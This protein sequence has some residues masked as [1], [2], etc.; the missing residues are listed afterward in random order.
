MAEKLNFDL[1]TGRN[2]LGKKL[3]ENASK[4]SNLRNILQTAAGVFAGAIAVKAFDAFTGAIGGAIGALNESIQLSAIQE[5]AVNDLNA[6]LARAGNLLPGVSEEL[7]EFASQL[8]ASSTFGDEVT[9][10]NI[11]LLQSLTNLD[12]DGLKVATQAAADLAAVQGIDLE[13]AIRLVGRAAN[14]QTDALRRY[15][16]TVEKGTSDSETF[17]NALEQ[18]NKQF[19][20]GAASQLNT[21]AGSLAQLQNTVGDLKETYGDLVTQNPLVVGSFRALGEILTEV[22]TELKAL[23]PEAQDFVTEGLIALADGAIIAA[24]ATDVLVR[25]IEL[26]GR[27][28][29]VPVQG[30]RGLVGAIT[31][32]VGITEGALDAATKG[33]NDNFQA[34]ND[35]IENTGTF[36]NLS[37]RIEDFK[38][39]ALAAAQEVE[40]ARAAGTQNRQR[41]S[42]VEDEVNGQILES[43]RKLQEELDKLVIEN[44]I[45]EQEGVIA[46]LG[47]EDE[48]RNAEIERLFEFEQAKTELLLAQE[49]ERASLL[50]DEEEKR[51]ANLVA[52]QKKELAD[53][54]IK[55]KQ[56][57]QQEKQRVDAQRAFSA[58]LA[59]IAGATANAVAAFSKKGS[60]E[61]FVAQK[62]AAVAQAIVATNLAAAQALAVPPAPNVGLAALAR[63]QG[64]ISI[65][66]II[67]QTIQGFKDGGFIGGMTGATSGGDNTLIQAREGELVLNSDQQRRLLGLLDG[68][69]SGSEIIIQ[70]D[71]RE[72]ARAVRDQMVGGF[73]L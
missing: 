32:L 50:A 18:I 39:R 15:G 70:I 47:A 62:A 40:N 17:A 9:L 24:Q 73:A 20:G 27:G 12:K 60:K 10:S 66:A 13:S 67:G 3:D 29:N 69:G 48:R 16:V 28:L 2:D 35:T 71:G 31:D 54:D 34:I 53:N 37:I 59:G 1:L 72:I 55:N 43:R 25:V 19:G 23:N 61:A 11:A 7:Q 45:K 46:R 51:L 64:A 49:I 56:I 44:A 22:N 38:N 4:A 14:G 52:L 30:I 41:E 68:G 58:Q 57:I 26:F 42:Q 63:G 5:K 36:E 65:A 33:I 21:Y 8:Q 6:S